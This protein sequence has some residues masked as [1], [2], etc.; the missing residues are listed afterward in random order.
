MLA[1]IQ[2]DQGSGSP[3]RPAVALLRRF[4]K[5]DGPQDGGPTPE[6]LAVLRQAQAETEE[7]CQIPVAFA[8]L[9]ANNSDLRLRTEDGRLE[10]ATRHISPEPLVLDGAPSQLLD[11]TQLLLIA[12]DGAHVSEAAARQACL[13]AIRRM[14]AHRPALYAQ[15][16]CWK[17]VDTASA[18]TE[19]LS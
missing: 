4:L 6:D 17:T 1:L 14:R 13:T 18:T 9:P 11:T 12:G 3:H 16:L 15:I 8:H 19:A 2:T 7:T 10:Q 5:A